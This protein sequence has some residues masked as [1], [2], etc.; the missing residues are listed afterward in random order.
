M[1]RSPSYDR[2]LSDR[3][4]RN[5]LIH[6]SSKYSSH[7]TAAESPTYRMSSQPKYSSA[8]LD[9]EDDGRWN[10]YTP[11]ASSHRKD[12][13]DHQFHHSRW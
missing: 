8:D 10:D 13:R 12:K 3:S 6:E 1:P 7:S 2:S 9:D 5:P 4:R 11:E